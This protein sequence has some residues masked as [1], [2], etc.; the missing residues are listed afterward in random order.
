MKQEQKVQIP[1]E[2]IKMIRKFGLK[3]EDAEI[4]F[5]TQINWTAVYSDNKIYCTEVNCE[6]F[7]ELDDEDLFSHTR[8]VHNWGDFPCKVDHCSYV[9]YSK[10]R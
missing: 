10:V 9:G 8:K 6:Y 4:L 5:Q 2:F 1:E 3:E 7:T